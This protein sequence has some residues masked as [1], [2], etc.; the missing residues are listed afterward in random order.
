[1]VFVLQH[2][3]IILLKNPKKRKKKNPSHL[4]IPV[5][6][7]FHLLNTQIIYFW[8]ALPC[9]LWAFSCQDARG[10]TLLWQCAHLLLQWLL[11][12]SVGSRARR[13]QQL[14][15]LDSSA[16][17]QQLWQTGLVAACGIFPDQGSVSSALEGRIFTEPPGKPHPLFLKVNARVRLCNQFFQNRPLS[18]QQFLLP[19]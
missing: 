9:C 8:L 15:Y 4:S 14:Q 1:M 7:T 11:L 12:W 18:C 16:Q 5:Y 17:A 2:Y 10:T 19:V 13:L 3:L 6:V